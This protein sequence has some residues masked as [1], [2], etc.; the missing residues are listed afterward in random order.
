MC[1]Q[2]EKS[3][4]LC[5]PVLCRGPCHTVLP[6]ETLKFLQRV[7]IPDSLLLWKEHI[8]LVDLHQ[9]ERLSLTL[10]RDGLLKR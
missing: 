9:A 7:N 1:L 6:E 5:V 3:G 10:L 8:A 2:E 4:G